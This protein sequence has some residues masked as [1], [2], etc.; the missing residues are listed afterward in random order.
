MAKERRTSKAIETLEGIALRY[1]AQNN[2][3]V[4]LSVTSYTCLS[5]LATAGID[6]K[7]A[8]AAIVVVLLAV[9]KVCASLGFR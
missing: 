4:T 1:T 2:A 5:V 3:V 6:V 7:T 9:S 8:A